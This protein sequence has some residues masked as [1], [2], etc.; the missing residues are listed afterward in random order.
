MSLLIL[1]TVQELSRDELLALLGQYF[2][3]VTL[4]RQRVVVGSVLVPDEGGGSFRT[5]ETRGPSS[6][7]SSHGL[8]RAKYLVALASNA[9]LGSIAR[10]TSIYV[11]ANDI[12]Q[13]DAAPHGA[14]AD[15]QVLLDEARANEQRWRNDL[16]TLSVT[17]G[18]AQQS[19]LDKEAAVV[20][21]QHHVAVL[22]KES[23]DRHAA[24]LNKL[25]V[26]AQSAQDVAAAT[27]VGALR[28]EIQ[29]LHEALATARARS[30]S[31]VAR[32]VDFEDEVRRGAS[33]AEAAATELEGMALLLRIA[34]GREIEILERESRL[35]AEL[36]RLQLEY[37]NTC[38]QVAEA[39]REVGQTRQDLRSSIAV[40][41]AE[42]VATRAELVSVR[43]ALTTEHLHN[44]FLNRFLRWNQSYVLRPSFTAKRLV[45]KGRRATR[46]K[47]WREAELRYRAVLNSFPR[48]RGV[49]M[50]YG[51]AVKEQGDYAA[52]FGAYGKAL[53]LGHMTADTLLHLG[54]A[55]RELGLRS[56][57]EQSL[58]QALRLRPSMPNLWRDLSGLGWTEVALIDDVL[59]SNDRTVTTRPGRGLWFGI[60]VSR[61]RSLA[62]RRN[63]RLANLHYCKALAVA[64]DDARIWLLY[65]HALKES[66]D[67]QKALQ[68]Y[69]QALVLDPLNQEPRLHVVPLRPVQLSSSH[70]LARV[71]ARAKPD[72]IHVELRPVQ[73]LEL[74]QD[75]CFITTGGDPQF[76]L[77]PSEGGEFPEGLV[78]VAMKVRVADPLLRPL[79][80]VWVGDAVQT[81]RLPL[82]SGSG[83]LQWTLQLPLSVTALRLDPTADPGVKVAIEEMTFRSRPALEPGQ[84]L[85][86]LQPSEM[87]YDAWVKLYDTMTPSDEDAIRERVSEL[88]M[89][90]LLSL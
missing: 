36:T 52:A 45:L 83:Q 42:L 40:Q 8:P 90:P 27:A 13:L 56:G 48:L 17:L 55:Q 70:A 43:Q 86:E 22:A 58:L 72:Q 81:L 63:W 35:R 9:E 25:R 23:A 16:Q 14:L 76:A 68:S 62:A 15:R 29:T 61:A 34:E 57:A 30:E 32:L 71:V 73:E 75:G 4:L 33:R 18:S 53:E 84:V 59:S 47:R 65:G 46:R 2:A 77:H 37:D 28:H 79:L 78:T 80:Y 7:E 88:P 69:L 54:H 44:D 50:Q 85:P 74:L 87:E 64:P 66:G 49:W 21:L 19:L 12:P 39:Q 24:E 89:R 5:F 60:H 20:A 51:H 41:D 26:E 6:L 10:S 1:F 67:T 82:I 31:D 38:Q 3:H 11:S